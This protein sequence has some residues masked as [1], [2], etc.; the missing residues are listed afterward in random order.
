MR[1]ATRQNARNIHDERSALLIERLHIEAAYASLI[2]PRPRLRTVRNSGGSC[3]NAKDAKRESR[4]SR[5][6]SHETQ[7]PPPYPQFRAERREYHRVS[8]IR[9]RLLRAIRNRAVVKSL[10]YNRIL[11]PY[12]FEENK[13]S[14]RFFF[15]P[16][17]FKIPEGRDFEFI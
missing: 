15:F 14:G 1:T 8:M 17:E 13:V 10:L 6:E 9:S 11:Q 3:G 16:R 5:K 4:L 7:F 2:V 12:I